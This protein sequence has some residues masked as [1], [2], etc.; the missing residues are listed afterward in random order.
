M[1]TINLIVTHEVGLHARPASMFVQTAASFTSDI[2][3]THKDK[4]VN[5]KS[6]LGVLTLG[7]HKDTEIT[8]NA[9]GPDA[10]EA[11]KALKDLVQDNFGEA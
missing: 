11:L 5:A 3:I 4:T 10:D 1:P 6:I 7:V 8:L 9:E 2:E